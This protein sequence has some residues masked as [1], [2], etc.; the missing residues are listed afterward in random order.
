MYLAYY[1]P[2][3]F[4]FPQGRSAGP[5]PRFLGAHSAGFARAHRQTLGAHAAAYARLRRRLGQDDNTDQSNLPPDVGTGNVPLGPISPVLVPSQNSQ[6]A[7]WTPSPV[8]DTTG[9]YNYGNL[10]APAGTQ[11][12]NLPT[13]NISVTIPSSIPGIAPTQLTTPVTNLARPS[14]SMYLLGGLALVAGMAFAGG[15]GKR[16]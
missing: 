3:Q 4:P 15:G 1:R 11:V 10:T 8:V 13:G 12:R 5:Y 14:I 16:R 9:T 6:P 7:P 2:G